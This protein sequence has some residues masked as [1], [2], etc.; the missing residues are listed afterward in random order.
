MPY[1][2]CFRCDRLPYDACLYGGSERGVEQWPN[3]IKTCSELAVEVPSWKFDRW[4]MCNPNCPVS[5]S[6]DPHLHLPHGGRAD[7][8]GAADTVFNL[9][10]AK[11]VALNVLFE[12][13]DFASLSRLVHGTKMAAAYWVLRT[14]SGKLITIEYVATK[15]DPVAIVREEGRRDVK[16]RVGQPAMEIDDLQVAMLA[17]KGK[18]LAVVTKKWRFTATTSPFPFGKKAENKDKVLLDVAIQPLYDADNDVV[19]PHGIIGQAYDGDSVAVNGKMDEHKGKE[20]TTVAQVTDEPAV[21]AQR[22]PPTS[23]GPPMTLRA[24]SLKFSC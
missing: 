10:S 7:F 22:E 12:A 20:S 9:L 21:A 19:A 4:N 5:A 8:R 23:V 1:N 13:A 11:D 6:K 17:A 18:A 3:C 2:G 24:G 14:E 15:A 16:V